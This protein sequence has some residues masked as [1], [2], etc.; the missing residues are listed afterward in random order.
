MSEAKQRKKGGPKR[1]PGPGPGAGAEPGRA[2]EGRRASGAGGGVGADPRTALSL[3]SFGACLLLAWFIFQQSEKF[4][5]VDNKYQFMEMSAKEF[6]DLKNK[7]S[8]LSEKLESTESI[9]QEATSSMALVTKFEQ[10]VSSLHSTIYDIQNSEQLLTQKIQ[11]IN[12]K[13]ENVSD[14]W[15]RSL[16]EMTANTVILKSEAKRVHTQVTAQINSAEQGVKS[17]TER[18]KD[19][20][21]STV[22]NIRTLKSQE[23]DDLSRVEKQLGS[24]TKAVEKLEEEQS[25]LFARDLD[26][27]NKLTAYEPKVE[28]CKTHMPVIEN[29]IHSVLKVSQELIG[30]EKKMEDLA[31]Q[32][33]NMEDDM[34]KAVSEIME[35]QK[36]LEGMQFDNSILK[37]QNE[38][39]VL[40]EKVQ[41]FIVSQNAREKGTLK[42]HN[43]PSKKFSSGGEQ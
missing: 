6:Q 12:V 27:N 33:F 24:D 14:S 2:G 23:D 34:L 9:L 28:E 43:L 18:L 15:K 35:M 25:N 7:V 31:E 41:E 30:I 39:V 8:L 13:F 21:D 10:E 26:L 19:L 42:E 17:L 1:G 20:E 29:A 38:L 32:M 16:D 40:K 36:A 22:R 11:S 4:A 5:S 37:M 3:L